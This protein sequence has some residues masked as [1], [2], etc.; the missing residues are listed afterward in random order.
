MA[1]KE[2][3]RARRAYL[4]HRGA[5]RAEVSPDRPPALSRRAGNRVRIASDA[6]VGR[7]AGGGVP[8]TRRSRAILP[9]TEAG[10]RALCARAPQP[11]RSD[12]APPGRRGA[13]SAA[14]RARGTNT[15]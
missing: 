7:N 14:R 15:A 1:G 6:R 5:T 13:L 4:Q 11:R 10:G 3:A 9:G 8:V 2:L 12:E